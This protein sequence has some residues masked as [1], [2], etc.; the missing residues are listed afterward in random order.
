[1]N[2]PRHLRRVYSY[3]GA[4]SS[5]SRQ[6]APSPVTLSKFNIAVVLGNSR[7][8]VLRGYVQRVVSA[9]NAAT[10]G[11]YIEVDIPRRSR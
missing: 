8:P 7:W 3:R 2:A 4:F 5:L 9:V 6:L 10:P 1:M 11:S